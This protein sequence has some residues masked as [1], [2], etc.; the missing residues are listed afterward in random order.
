[1]T[2]KKEN[3]IDIIA[4]F[5]SLNKTHLLSLLQKRLSLFS[6]NHARCDTRTVRRL[7]DSGGVQ[8][9]HPPSVQFKLY[10]GEVLRRGLYQELGG[11]HP[12][13]TKICTR[14][15]VQST[16]PRFLKAPYSPSVE[17]LQSEERIK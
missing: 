11:I 3:K 16:S 13:P 7:E 9:L 4:V 15:W 17:L 1:M 6:P 14:N 2:G 12:V 5:F 8:I 10:Q